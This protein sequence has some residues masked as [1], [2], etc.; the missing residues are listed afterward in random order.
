MKIGLIADTHIPSTLKEVPAEVLSY[1]E[2]VDGILHAGDSTH[3]ASLHQLEEVAPVIAIR[4]NHDWS[5]K[6][7]PLTRTFDAEGLNIVLTHGHGGWKEYV[8]TR[9]A[10]FRHRLASTYFLGKL[11]I[12]HP[13][14][15]IIIFGHTHIAYC[16]LH[17]KT[18][19]VNP[20][21]LAPLYIP[22]NS[23][24]KAGRLTIGTY[25]IKVEFKDFYT[26]TKQVKWYGF[27]RDTIGR[28]LWPLEAE[29]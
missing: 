18:L 2:G 20:G 6:D 23:G 25:S 15:D 24:P 29:E 10:H 26:N 9:V 17:R 3:A 14:A 8:K 11:L 28:K 19:L 7:Y 16:E 27:N 22:L 1:M 5:M 12:W 13:E 4:G 21:S